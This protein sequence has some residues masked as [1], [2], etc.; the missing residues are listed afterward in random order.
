MQVIAQCQA[1]RS[2]NRFF[3]SEYSRTRSACPS[4][5]RRCSVSIAS[6]SANTPGRP[7]LRVGSAVHRIV[8][9]ASSS[10]NTPGPRI[11][12]CHLK[13][14]LKSQSLLR[15]RILPDISAIPGPANGAGMV[16][17]ASSSANTPGLGVRWSGGGREDPS[18]S[19][20]RQR[21]LPDDFQGMIPGSYSN[22][23]NRFFVSEY[24]RTRKSTTRWPAGTK[25]SIASSSANTPG[26]RGENPRPQGE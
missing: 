6:S 7:G 24:S 15:Q 20:L 25:V 10:A 17:I 3:V 18:Q 21:I 14:D 5:P 9:I 22:G 8:S 1:A 19:L 23:L 4:L 12:Q 2:L 26:R 11:I 13:Y 16:S